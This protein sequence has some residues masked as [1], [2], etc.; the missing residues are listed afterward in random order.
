MA[1]DTD[2]YKGLRDR[3]FQIFQSGAITILYEMGIG[4][5]ELMAERIQKMGKNKLSVYRRFMEHGV[6]LGIGRFET[7]FLKMIISGLRG[8]PVVRLTDS[9]YA[10]AAGKTGRPECHIIRGTIAGAAR[11]LL[12]KEFDCVEEKCTS[13]SDPYCEFRLKEKSKKPENA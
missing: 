13:K 4:Y 2:F 12:N 10:A 1:I 5:G 8:E 6:Y 9:F 11:I 7:P 3:L